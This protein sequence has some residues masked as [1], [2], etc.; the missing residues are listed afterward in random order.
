[1]LAEL[2]QQLRLRMQSN[3]DRCSAK[4]DLTCTFPNTPVYSYS[5]FLIV[6]EMKEVLANVAFSEPISIA[7]HPSSES[8]PRYR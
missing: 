4:L 3:A 1:M 6:L 8:P 2:H 5:H 7:F